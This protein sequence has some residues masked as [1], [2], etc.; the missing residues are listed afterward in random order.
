MMTTGPSGS[1]SMAF[2][3]GSVVVPFTSET[4][5]SACPVT[6][7]TRLDLPALRMPKKPMC[8]RSE[9]GTLVRLIRI[10]PQNLK[11]RRLELRMAS[12]FSLA[13]TRTLSLGMRAS[14]LSIISKPTFFVSS[15][16]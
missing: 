11:S 13:I 10:P 16:A 14:S 6:A 7:L 15:L 1:S 8:S 5:D 4:S 12:M 9:D 2:L 3:T